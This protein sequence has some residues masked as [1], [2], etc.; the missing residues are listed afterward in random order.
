MT[1]SG[2]FPFVRLIEAP[3]IAYPEGKRFAEA[4]SAQREVDVRIRE[5]HC[6]TPRLQTP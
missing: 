1:A 6:S 4:I 3:G 2:L 5:R